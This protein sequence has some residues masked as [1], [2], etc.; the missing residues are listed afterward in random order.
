M[1]VT[2]TNQVA[3]PA[4]AGQCVLVTLNSADALA[5]LPTL[6]NGTRAVCGSSSKV[7][8]VINVDKLGNTFEVQPNTQQARFDSSSTPYELAVAESIVLG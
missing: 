4:S 7:G 3:A 8:Q 2:V 5:Q 1:S 6:T